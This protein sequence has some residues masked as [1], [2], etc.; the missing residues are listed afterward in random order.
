MKIQ[1]EKNSIINSPYDL[2]YNLEDV[3]SIA[4]LESQILHGNPACF[5]ISGYRGAGK[6]SL[7]KKVQKRLEKEKN[8]LFIY[9]NFSKF[10]KYALILR[11]MIREIYLSLSDKQNEYAEL[12]RKHEDLIKTLELLYDRTFNEVSF[13]LNSKNLFELESTLILVINELTELYVKYVLKCYFDNSNYK[14]YHRE[15]SSNPAES[16]D[17]KAVR[18]D[19][20][21]P[22]ILFEIKT[23]QLSV[24]S[25]YILIELLKRKMEAYNSQTS[26]KNKLVVFLNMKEEQERYL[27]HI[28]QVKRVSYSD[29]PILEDVHFIQLPDYGKPFFRRTLIKQVHNLICRYGD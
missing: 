9:M 11:K 22:D 4:Q 1:I 12:K 23:E 24:N 10:E 21:G 6:T 5:L 29:I 2:N 25:I 3:E 8:I 14:L 16:F 13:N 18:R 19:G 17:L 27:E 26:K 20:G 15:Q 28:N 7:I